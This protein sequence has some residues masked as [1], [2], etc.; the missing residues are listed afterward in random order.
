MVPMSVP[1]SVLLLILCPHISIF[2][3]PS[4][5][6]PN[7]SDTEKRLICGD[8]DQKDA[9]GK[10]WSQVPFSQARFH[11]NTFLQ[12]RGYYQAKYDISNDESP[13]MKVDLGQITYVSQVSVPFFDFDMKRKRYVVGEPLTPRLLDQIEQWVTERLQSYGYG[14]PIVRSEADPFTGIVN[15]KIKTGQ[16]Q[17]VTGIR[18]ETTGGIAAGFLDRYNAFEMGNFFNGDLLTVTERRVTND[19]VLQGMH[20]S[21]LCKRDGIT[22]RRIGVEGAPRLVSFGIG[23]NTEGLLI[24]KSTFKN[25]RIGKRASSYDLTAQASAI[26]QEVSASVHW[27]HLP[28]PSRRYLKPVALFRHQNENPFEIGFL[29]T[30]ILQGTSL[31]TQSVGLTLT[32]GPSLEWVK[33]LHGF[34]PT[35][36]HFL[37]LETH[38]TLTSH[39][40]ELQ[41]HNPRTGFTTGITAAVNTESMLST[42]S[43]QRL[44]WTGEWLWNYGGYDPP[45]WLF[46]VRAGADTLISDE[47][48]VSS[49]RLPPEFFRFLGGAQSL[50]GFGRYELPYANL[51]GEQ[52]GAMT[53]LFT[54]LEF[55]FI[56]TPLPLSF[57]PFLFNDLGWLGNSPF[58]L[59]S[60]LFQSPG[61]GL[62]W[63]SPIGAFRATL[64]HGIVS[65]EDKK[66]PTHFQFYLS[67]GEEF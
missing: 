44:N 1:T 61:F 21:P 4:Y 6:T 47:R 27:Y 67:F 38:A 45:F 15:V 20:F 43:A 14:C 11:M 18:D 2:G 41:I 36:T 19:G 25:T 31:D 58:G 28:F 10:S 22:L 12:D 56:E 42:A 50:R 26:H 53:S 65:P 57:Q 8:S 40:Y 13:S 37:S 3:D 64:A 29:K 23:L 5:S 48:A 32:L 35:F 55:R 24:L 52:P 33:T 59:D 54:G 49:T 63:D 30:Q 60:R 39:D 17:I 62:R 66:N 46:G 51:S 34:G 16:K 7:F 9:I